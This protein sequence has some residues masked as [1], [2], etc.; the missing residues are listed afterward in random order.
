MDLGIQDVAKLL[1]VTEETIRKWL[2]QGKIPSY[3]LQSEYRFSLMEIENWMIERK[4]LLE[5]AHE[6][7]G[8]KRGP[9]QFNLFRALHRGG[10][11][12]LSAKNKKEAILQ[13]SEIAAKKLSLDPKMLAELLL[14]RENMMPTSLGNGIGVPHTR[15][16]VVQQPH[17]M[18]LLAY[19][20]EPLEYGALDGKPV[21]TLFFIFSSEDTRHLNL[22]AKLAHLASSTEMVRFIESR[23]GEQALLEKIQN[24][25]A[26]IVSAST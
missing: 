14:D 13:G 21:R 3:Q 25:E 12:T 19:L 4:N 2:S 1:R 15:D 17:E 24:W 6:E 20:K 23:P 11:I 26:G 16:F 9:Q 10:V 18:V 8:V 7:V 5:E 22:L